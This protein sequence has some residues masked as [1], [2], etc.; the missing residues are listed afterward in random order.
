MKMTKK[1]MVATSLGLGL[2][3]GMLSPVRAQDLGAILK[4]GAILLAIDKFG[5]DIDKFVNRILGDGTREVGADTKVVPVLSLGKGTYVGAVQ[6]TGPTRQ[7]QTVKAVAQV[8]GEARIGI[9]VRVKGLIPISDRNVKDLSTLKRV[10]GIG[11]TGIIDG[12][13]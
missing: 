3:V 13:I 2:T 1:T 7:V 8:E 4:G 12:K 11:I 9:K 6:I 5:P 10:P